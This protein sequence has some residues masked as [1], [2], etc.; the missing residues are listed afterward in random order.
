MYTVNNF[1]I[2][3]VSLLQQKEL[4]RF[5]KNT[6]VKNKESNFYYII[7]VL[8]KFQNVPSCSDFERS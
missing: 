7:K 1:L 3:K 8:Q 5:S 2:L 4:R 6:N